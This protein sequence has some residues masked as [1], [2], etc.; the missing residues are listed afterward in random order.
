MSQK[1][2]VAGVSKFILTNSVIQSISK[3]GAINATV[4]TV[5]IVNNRFRTLGQESFQFVSWDSVIIDN[6]TFEFL[7]QGSLN[8]IKGPSEDQDAYFPFT[9]NFIGYENIK[10]LVTQIPTSVNF[11]VNSNSFGH[12]CDCKME[13]Y[14]KSITGHTGLSSPFQD[15]LC[16]LD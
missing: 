4:A 15:L 3:H 10:S 11:K 1:S 5:E 8:A 6:N 13:T 7:E 16:C 14:I 2:V 9:N 12:T